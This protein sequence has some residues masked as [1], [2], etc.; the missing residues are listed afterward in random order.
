MCIVKG[1]QRIAQ[2]YY[3]TSAMETMQITSP[4]AQGDA[5]KGRHGSVEE[6]EIMSIK[7]EDPE[8]AVK[9][10]SN[11]EDEVKE[12]VIALFINIYICLVTG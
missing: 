2:T 7:Q 11:L 8:K 12:K 6:I 5:K 4:D 10:G 3:T 1:D 9:I